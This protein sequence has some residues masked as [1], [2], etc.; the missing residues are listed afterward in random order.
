MQHFKFN[1]EYISPVLNKLKTENKAA[2]M[3]GEFNINYIKYTQVL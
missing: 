2:I 1:T 3:A